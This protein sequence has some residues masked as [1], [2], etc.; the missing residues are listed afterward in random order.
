MDAF[1]SSKNK[2][3]YL[4]KLH[5]SYSCLRIIILFWILKKVT[6]FCHP[7]TRVNSRHSLRMF[8][9]HYQM[10]TQFRKI[11]H[12]IFS[13]WLLDNCFEHH[14]WAPCQ[15]KT[16]FINACKLFLT[17]FVFLLVNAT[18]TLLNSIEIECFKHL[19]GY[20]PDREHSILTSVAF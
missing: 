7:Q 4:S 8:N 17:F 10:H 14:K 1:F 15:L 11:S 16:L 18:L 19:I 6:S 9:F 13:I 5:F 20:E 2:Q 12:L 3:T